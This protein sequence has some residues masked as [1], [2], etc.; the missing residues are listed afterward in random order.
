VVGQ[1]T[2]TGIQWHIATHRQ[3]TALDSQHPRGSTTQMDTHPCRCQPPG[4]WRPH[5]ARQHRGPA[6]RIQLHRKILLGS[7]W[8]TA[9][10]WRRCHCTF[11][12]RKGRR[13]ELQTG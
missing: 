3:G 1:H 8:C 11:P 5:T 2:V 12:R 10:H 13:H 4:P 7:W 9:R 6:L